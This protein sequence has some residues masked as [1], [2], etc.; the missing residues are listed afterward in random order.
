[1]PGRGLQS[2][3]QAALLQTAPRQGQILWHWTTTRCSLKSPIIGP[4][5][6]PLW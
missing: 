4:V 5:R 1:M 6:T 3:A 2:G